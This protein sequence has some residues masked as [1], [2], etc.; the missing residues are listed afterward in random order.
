[1]RWITGRSGR[2]GPLRPHGG[3]EL[4]GLDAW[5]CGFESWQVRTVAQPQARVAIVGDCFAT[6]GQLEAAP[7]LAAAGRWREL[8]RWPGSYLVVARVRATTAVLGDLAGLYPVYYHHNAGG[9]RWAT[10]AAP[11]AAAHGQEPDPAMAAA[12]MVFPQPGLF[13]G[14]SL[15]AGVARVPP[16]CLLLLDQGR[17]RVEPYEGEVA[18]LPLAEAA[19]QLRQTLGEAVSARLAAHPHASFDL[20]GLDSSTLA[21]LGAR[22]RP[23]TAATFTDERLRNDDLAYATRTAAAV[24]GLTHHVVAGGPHTDYYT[25][26]AEN[27]GQPVTDA[28]N[29]YVVTA[30]MKDA[31]LDVAHE[32]GS[33]LH[34]TGAAGD[35]VLGSSIVYLSD[36]LRERRWATA[37]AH[38]RLHARTLRS[39]PRE[40]LARARPAARRP[41]VEDLRRAAMVL[42]RPPQ[43]WAPAASRPWGWATMLATADWLTPD[44]RRLLAEELEHA[45]DQW[46]GDT[47]R[48]EALAVFTD[49]QEVEQIGRDLAQFADAVY[50]V[51][52]IHIAAPYLDNEVLRLCLAV[53]AEERAHPGSYKPLL[54]GMREVVPDFVLARTTKGLMNTVCFDGIR[55]HEGAIRDLLG[56]ASRLAENG[57]LDPGR[58]GQSLERVRN[59]L[60]APL[61]AIH[62]AVTVEAWW[63]GISS[64]AGT[65][66]EVTRDEARAAT[67]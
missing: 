60:P 67:A 64:D 42:R 15:F 38:A 7:S 45:A 18:P 36:L 29:A 66:W 14:R 11:L 49:R 19:G 62:L 8:T 65:W 2:T 55:R 63:R 30:A 25:G 10:A 37:Y 50:A 31:A 48:P 44:A 53:P 3:A 39:S 20:A 13:P 4:V 56:P 16:G 41:L 21:C 52:G 35:T 54:R 33:T 43:W 1:M 17:A 23:V 59:G 24:P 47:R 27:G 32:H 57:L 6:A 22:E 46:S 40:V 26:I 58:P 28:P 34:F 61:G 5:A 9:V 12:A 51:C